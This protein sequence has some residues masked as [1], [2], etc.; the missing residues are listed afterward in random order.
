MSVTSPA[1][2]VTPSTRVLSE[3]SIATPASASG[4]LVES[5]TLAEKASSALPPVP[6][7]VE[8]PDTVVLEAVAPPAPLLVEEE[9]DDVPVSSSPQATATE[10]TPTVQSTAKSCNLIWPPSDARG[11]RRT[12][13][14]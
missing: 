9:D 3:R 13:T 4:M 1:A 5:L 8:D 2:S 11:A 14:A 12:G 7:L 6:W 10:A